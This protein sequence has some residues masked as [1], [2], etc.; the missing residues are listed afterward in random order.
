MRT[1][2]AVPS[3]E[4]D[5]ADPFRIH[6]Y[7]N[8]TDIWFVPSVAFAGMAH[9]SVLFSVIVQTDPFKIRAV[10]GN[11]KTMTLGHIPRSHQQSLMK[12][13]CLGGFWSMEFGGKTR[14][15]VPSTVIRI[16]D[17]DLRPILCHYSKG[18]FKN[19]HHQ[20][21][22]IDNGIWTNPSLPI[23]VID[24]TDPFWIHS[25]NSCC[26]NNSSL[27]PVLSQWS[28]GIF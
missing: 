1:D 24:L 10:N 13:I 21:H 2:I 15:S 18:S 6:S 4:R 23:A 11:W 16:Y 14:S 3:C 9:A 27:Y 28:N 17:Y 7:R 12:R 19:L 20:C 25:V 5:R 22:S 8:G 26:R